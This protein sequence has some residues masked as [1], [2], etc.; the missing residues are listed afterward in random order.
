DGDGIS[1][2][3]LSASSGALALNGGQVGGDVDDGVTRSEEKAG[4]GKA[5]ALAAVDSNHLR[6]SAADPVDEL[7]QLGRCCTDFAP[8]DTSSVLVNCCRDVDAAVGID[9]DHVG[10][11][12]EPS[13]RRVETGWLWTLLSSG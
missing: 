8:A 7:D 9:P 13:S 6:A 5:V 4:Q 2:V 10:C 11:H 1:L 3:V 12:G